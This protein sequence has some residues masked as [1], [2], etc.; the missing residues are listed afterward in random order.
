MNARTSTHERTTA[1]TTVS[2]TVELDGVGR[3]DI[4]TG[5]GFLDHMLAA[6]AR[7]APL[8]IAATCTGDLQVDDHHTAED[9]ALAAGARRSTWP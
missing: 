6:L 9:C 8:D 2:V 1:E 3:A 7:H 4:R 5:I